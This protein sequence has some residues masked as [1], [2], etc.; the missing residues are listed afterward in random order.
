MFKYLLLIMTITFLSNASEICNYDITNNEELYEFVQNV[1][2][3]EN[4]KSAK[5]VII[6]G[7]GEKSNYLCAYSPKLIAD[8]SFSV[9][10]RLENGKNKTFSGSFNETYRVVMAARLITKN[11]IIE[12]DDLDV[13]NVD[14]LRSNNGIFTS[15]NDLI[16]KVSKYGL[17]KGQIINAS[18]VDYPNLVEKDKIVRV[19]YRNGALK[20][21]SKLIS[22]QSG[23]KG[24]IVKLKSL[25]G[26]SFLYGVISD[27]NLVELNPKN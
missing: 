25:S 19:I 21:E 10:I 23:K 11:H 22:L 12:A 17:S 16:G 14:H 20:L 24:D 6:R 3:Q 4:D 7:L 5:Q 26:D 9:V 15:R 1:I 13:K 2:E 18:H 27:K 8:K